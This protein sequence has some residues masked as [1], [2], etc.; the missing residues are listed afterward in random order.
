VVFTMVQTAAETWVAARPME[1]L[2]SSWLGR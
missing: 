2:G 1:R